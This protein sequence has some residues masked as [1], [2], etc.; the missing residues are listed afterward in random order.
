[1]VFISVLD[2][3]K[4]QIYLPAYFIVGVISYVIL[5]VKLF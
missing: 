1:L 5:F 3:S 2:K 4:T